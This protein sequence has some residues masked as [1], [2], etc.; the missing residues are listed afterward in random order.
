MLRRENV[1]ATATVSKVGSR[2]DGRVSFICSAKEKKPKERR[3]GFRL[4]HSAVL[5]ICPVLL[6]FGE[7]W[8]FSPLCR[9]EHRRV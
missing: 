6:A 3:P 9:A 2:T 8:V 5:P 7:G 1:V 4:F